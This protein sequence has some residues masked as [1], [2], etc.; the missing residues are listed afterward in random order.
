MLEAAEDAMRF[1]EGRTRDDL[2]QD[3]MLLR[4]VH[5]CIEVIGE[6]AARTSPEGRARVPSL[7]W[8]E[9]TKMRNILV[10]VYWGVDQ[11][12]LWETARNDLP[13]LAAALREALEAWTDEN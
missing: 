8:Q 13:V 5:Q 6:A 3:R 10:H 9:M 12:R 1:V 4:A 7:P 2:D 11:N